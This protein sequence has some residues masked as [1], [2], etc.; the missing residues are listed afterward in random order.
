LQP[1]AYVSV[2]VE[3]LILSHP[4][5][6]LHCWCF[7]NLA[8]ANYVVLRLQVIHVDTVA[9][10]EAKSK[11]DGNDDSMLAGLIHWFLELM[12]SSYQQM[13]E[14]DYCKSHLFVFLMLLCKYKYQPVSCATF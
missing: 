8:T 14:D 10:A 11:N 6:F 12:G 1:L 4:I 3:A 9:A 2:N 7:L 5:I 13:I